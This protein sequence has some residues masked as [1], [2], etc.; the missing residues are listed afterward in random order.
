MLHHLPIEC[1][2]KV[3]SA[4]ENLKKTGSNNDLSESEAAGETSGRC[5]SYP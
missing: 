2:E 1:E 5:W 4:R 3:H